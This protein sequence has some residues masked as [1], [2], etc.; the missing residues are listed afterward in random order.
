MDG[1]YFVEVNEEKPSSMRE[2]DR[3]QEGNRPMNMDEVRMMKAKLEVSIRDELA[4]FHLQTGMRV[5]GLEMIRHEAL[6][7]NGRA[8]ST[9]YDVRVR[10][11]V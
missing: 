2:T 3:K 6:A 9:V 10:A 5:T 11:E 4:S 1:G 8:V 7:A